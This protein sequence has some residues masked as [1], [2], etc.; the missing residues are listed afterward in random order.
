MEFLTLVENL[1]VGRRRLLGC[2]EHSLD[3][4]V[5]E[6]TP[7]HRRY[8]EHHYRSADGYGHAS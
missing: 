6:R 7:D 2:D 1:F 5:P 4:N 8:R 3:A